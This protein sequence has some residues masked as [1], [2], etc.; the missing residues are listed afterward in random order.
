M[1]GIM[2]NLTLFFSRVLRMPRTGG[3]MLALLT[4]LEYGHS[5]MADD[6]RP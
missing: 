3:F 1:L 5:E 4:G 2:E 6:V